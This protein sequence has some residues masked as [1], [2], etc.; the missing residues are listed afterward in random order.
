LA[1]TAAIIYGT[2]AHNKSRQKELEA[3]DSD[4]ETKKIDEGDG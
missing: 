3:R 4:D 2:D 1:G